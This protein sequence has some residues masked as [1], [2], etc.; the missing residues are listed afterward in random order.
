MEKHILTEK[1]AKPLGLYPHSKKIGNLLFLSGIGPRTAGT[2]I[3]PGLEMDKYGN[4]IAFDFEKRYLELSETNADRV[5][6]AGPPRP[7]S[8]PNM[9]AAFQP[10]QTVASTSA[11]PV[12]SPYAVATS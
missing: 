11:R 7:A 1:A 8:S 9:A 6:P 12:S 4:Y 3:I 2:D 10:S 5:R